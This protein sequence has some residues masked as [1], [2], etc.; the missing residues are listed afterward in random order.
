MSRSGTS[1]REG[2]DVEVGPVLV[3]SLRP[4][5][6]LPFYEARPVPA[7]YGSPFVLVALL[8][9]IFDSSLG[10]AIASV[11]LGA[12]LVGYLQRILPNERLWALCRHNFC[13]KAPR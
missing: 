10:Y 3:I 9:A 6:P 1:N 8:S 4:R 5:R 2:H 13:T 11:G 7:V 12:V